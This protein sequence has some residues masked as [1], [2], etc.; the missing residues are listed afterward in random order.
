MKFK[1]GLIFLLWLLL[2]HCEPGGKAGRSGDDPVI[3]NVSADQ[4]NAM[5]A[6]RKQDPDFVILD[7]RTEPEFNDGHLEGAILLDF[8][9]PTFQSELDKLA[10]NKAY[11]VYCRSGNR[12]SK[13]VAL[14]KKLQF[15]EIYHLNGGI[16]DWLANDLPV[17]NSF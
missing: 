14:M 15:N 17:V 7:F 1:T 8:Y 3:K 5:L 11:L 2:I 6:E 9:A 13:A 4:A 12:S 16:N 10:K